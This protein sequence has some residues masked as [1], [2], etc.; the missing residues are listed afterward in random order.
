[1]FRNKGMVIDD[2]SG[3][4]GL[5]LHVFWCVFMWHLG[6][7]CLKRRPVL[8]DRWEIL[9]KRAYP[10]LAE[11]VG[12]AKRVS[13]VCNILINIRRKRPAKPST[14]VR[15][16]PQPPISKKNI[17]FSMLRR[18]WG[19]LFYSCALLPVAEE[20]AYPRDRKDFSGGKRD[21]PGGRKR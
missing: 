5:Q 11:I 16:R 17:V 12:V 21:L 4:N 9:V 20:R 15:F 19:R 3:V 13:L 14:P 8:T 7:D 18:P 10:R 6:W 1:M 2:R